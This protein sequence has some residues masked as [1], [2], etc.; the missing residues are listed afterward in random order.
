MTPASDLS[1]GEYFARLASSYG[2]GEYY[3]KRRG[4]A[5]AEI[6]R[7][8]GKIDSLLD[9]GCGNG[10]YLAGFRE[11]IDPRFLVG[12]DLSLRMAQEASRRGVA[13]GIVAGD[14][15]LLPFRTASFRAI[16]CSH[17]LQFVADL[18]PCIVEIARCLAPGGI[19]VIAGGELGVRERLKILLGDERWSTF[20]AE[21]PRPRDVRIRRTLADYQDAAQRAGLS[22]DSQSVEF[23]ATWANLAEFYRVRWLPLYDSSAQTTLAGVLEELVSE[24]G[25][26]SFQMNESLLFCQRAGGTMTPR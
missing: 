2:A 5:L 19:F 1:V 10:T 16:F 8:L 20:R 25:E 15:T 12:A 23:S 11:A 4:A 18:P 3:R 22:V 6:G 14:A 7:R 13:N 24:R 21:M 17:V 26:E 9:L